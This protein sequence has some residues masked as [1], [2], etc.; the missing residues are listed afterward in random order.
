LPLADKPAKAATAVTTTDSFCHLIFNAPPG[1]AVF[2]LR[3]HAHLTSPISGVGCEIEIDASYRSRLALLNADRL[4]PNV[5][6]TAS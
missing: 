2:V 4:T 5:G 3:L 1:C 6:E